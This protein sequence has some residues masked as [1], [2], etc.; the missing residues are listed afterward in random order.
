MNEP[1]DPRSQR[2]SPERAGSDA[3]L[4]ASDIDFAASE[5]LENWLAGS[6][7]SDGAHTHVAP[8][9]RAGAMLDARNALRSR[10]DAATSGEFDRLVEE[11]LRQLDDEPS[12]LPESRIPGGSHAG[13]VRRVALR[14]QWVAA[15]AAGILLIV[16]IG[17]L[18]FQ[19][20]DFEESARNDAASSLDM[21]PP[22]AGDAGP[23]ATPGAT[24][25]TV[26]PEPVSPAQALA[27][28]QRSEEPPA[29]ERDESTDSDGSTGSGE[30]SGEATD[31]AEKAG[32]PGSVFAGVHAT[33]RIQLP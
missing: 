19:G 1:R 13:R 10:E 20:S 28:E 2:H 5:S 31:T 25:T 17:T 24:T 22:D 21:L 9:G 32:S 3:E 29:A 26:V 16:G 6:P 33:G 27:P 11:A 15:A 12:P 23:G 7:Q 30:T 4:A 14:P 8:T 18:V